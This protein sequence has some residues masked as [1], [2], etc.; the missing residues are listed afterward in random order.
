MESAVPLLS[1]PSS[2]YKLWSALHDRVDAILEDRK[3]DL[4]LRSFS[5]AWAAESEHQKHLREDS[6]L[7]IRGFDSVSS[8]LS[9]LTNNLSNIQQG[10]DILAQPS[11]P[12]ARKR[13][14]KRKES[15]NGQP[16]LKKHC[17][18]A[19]LQAGKDTNG[20]EIDKKVDSKGEDEGKNSPHDPAK[21]PNLKEAKSLAI[22]VVTKAASLARELKVIRPELKFMQERCALLEEENRRHREGLGKGTLQE[23]DDLMR[24]QL[25][26]LLSEKSRLANEN[27]NLIRE[28]QCLHQLVEYHQLTSQDILFSSYEEILHWTQLDIPSSAVGEANESDEHDENILT[29][30]GSS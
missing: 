21:S 30:G 13:E 20:F 11:V 7:L 18:V 6:L 5:P 27:A 1:S 24:L 29:D 19:D 16:M 8:S 28:N 14:S 3:L 17:R 2:D 9:Q 4:P 23:E 25:E 26:V 12:R 22:S 10:L 15:E